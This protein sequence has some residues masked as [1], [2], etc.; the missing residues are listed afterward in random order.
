[1]ALNPEQTH[2]SAPTNHSQEARGRC[3]DMNGRRA[4]PAQPA[5]RSSRSAVTRILRPDRERSGSNCRN[6]DIK[7]AVD[8]MPTQGA[9]RRGH[10]TDT[11]DRAREAGVRTRP[12]ASAIKA[13]VVAAHKAAPTES[14]SEAVDLRSPQRRDAAPDPCVAQILTRRHPEWCTYEA[15]GE[16]KHGI[17]AQS[18]VLLR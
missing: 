17:C 15:R 6:T 12:Q 14:T 5:D 9:R 8:H 16:R 13:T 1:M 2:P 18:L 11:G 4:S 3:R 10:R 7:G